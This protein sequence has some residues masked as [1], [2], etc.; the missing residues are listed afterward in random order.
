MD[1][2]QDTEQGCED[3]GRPK[4]GIVVPESVA[5]SRRNISVLVWCDRLDAGWNGNLYRLRCEC[6]VV[7]C[8]ATF[9]SDHLGGG[10]VVNP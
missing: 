4:T 5:S 1:R 7:V 9:D 8:D 6:D 10:K 3:Q 2:N